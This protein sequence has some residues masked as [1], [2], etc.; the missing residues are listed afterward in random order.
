MRPD[1]KIALIL[2]AMLV[3][4]L[5][6]EPGQRVSISDPRYDSVGAVYFMSDQPDGNYLFAAEINVDGKLALRNAYYTGGV[7]AHASAPGPDPLFSQ[8][9]IVTSQKS[10][11]VVTVNPGSGTLSA[12]QINPDDPTSLEIIGK[13]VRSG[14]DFPVSVT[15][16]ERGD[17]VCALNGGK[18]NGISCFKL[19]TRKGLTPWKNTMR[20]LNLNQT[21]PATGP[22][23]SVGDIEFTADGNMVVVSVKG[24][25]PQP[26]YMAIWE[27]KPDGTL[28]DTHATIP[29]GKLPWSVTNIRG[30]N[31]TLAADA[32][33]GFDI[34]DLSKMA[35]P[36]AKA[37]EFPV[38]AQGAVCWSGYSDKTGNYYLA[39][40]NTAHITEI[41][42]DDNLNATV[43]NSYATDLN[44]GTI[45][46]D[47]TPVNG[48]DYLYVLAANATSIE[49]FALD[50]PGS[51]NRIQKLDVRSPSTNAGLVITPDFIAGLKTWNKVI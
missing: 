37:A 12:F 34:F 2:S 46:F 50:G 29:G 27:V 17:M 31:A 26:G 28:S 41:H 44:D 5:A 43:V 22:E 7:G 9:S 47:I 23:M 25:P 6:V 20:P 42:I 48:K 24:N 36:S 21:T 18:M 10:N 19:N 14:G 49:V 15:M 3:P 16:N 38:T 40:L 13:P 32:G 1:F 35:E 11:V 33:L 8:G 45:E 4:V 30:K 39:D 51:A